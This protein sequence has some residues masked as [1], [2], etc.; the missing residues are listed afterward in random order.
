MLKIQ[1]TDNVNSNLIDCINKNLKFN[2]K[3][4]N[5][6]NTQTIELSIDE[7]NHCMFTY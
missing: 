7:C 5:T 1:G 3:S 6:L 4:I 2:G